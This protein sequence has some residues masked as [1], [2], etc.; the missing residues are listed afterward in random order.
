MVGAFKDVDGGW[1][2]S[3]IVRSSSNEPYLSA[4]TRRASRSASSRRSLGA[5]LGFLIAYA[6][7]RGRHAARRSAR[8]SRPSRA[9]RRTSAAS[10][11][12]SRSSRRSGTI[13]IVTKF[14]HDQL[15]IDLYAHGLHALRDDGRRDRLPLLPDPADDPRDRA[16]DRRAPARVARG[17]VE[18]RR[19]L[20]P[21]LAPRRPAGADAVAAR[22]VHPALRQRLRRLRDRVR[23]DSAAASTSCRS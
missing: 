13:G 16:R 11:S 14:L 3:N 4:T 17:V 2:L 8:R 10:R 18:P 6:A 1:T 19:E 20:V 23:A 15:G 21:V 5:L 7:I 12:R 9:W 22:R